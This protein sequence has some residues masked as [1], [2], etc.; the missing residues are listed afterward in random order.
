MKFLFYIVIFYSHLSPGFLSYQ[1]TL[2]GMYNTLQRQ[3]V[4]SIV[5][6]V[7]TNDQRVLQLKV[8]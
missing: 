7:K 8:K 3:K 4:F 2:E 6:L 1:D 5:S